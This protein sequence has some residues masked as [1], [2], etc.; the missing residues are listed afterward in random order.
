MSISRI[1]II[2]LDDFAMLT[3]DTSYGYIGGE[4]VQH[5]L[6]ARAWRDLGIDV[7]IIVHD[8]GQPR[9]TGV[10]GIR[11]VACC[12]RQDGVK[13]VRYVY[14]RMTSVLRAMREIDADLYYQSPAGGLAGLVAGFAKQHGKRSIVRI[15]SDSDCMRLRLPLGRRIDRWLYEYGLRN[16]S[17]VAAQTERQR[18]LL[19]RNF[20]V[21]SE[22]MNIVVDPPSS[23]NA[24]ASRDVDVLWVGNFRPVKR[25]DIVLEMARRRPQYRFA[26]VGGSARSPAG[27][28]YFSRVAQEAAS[29]SNVQMTGTVPYEHVGTWFDRA[30]VHVNT[31]DYE[32]FP[33]TFL[34]A[35]IRR[36]PVVSFFDPDNLIERR[37][38]GR[39]CRDVEDMCLALDELL[40]DPSRCAAI[41]E[42]SYAA[43][44][45]QYS[46]REI[47]LRYLEA[48]EGRSASFRVADMTHPSI[49]AANE[50]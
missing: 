49:R 5:V 25:P 4:S 22:I 13:L 45:S 14:P 43:A 16:A 34:Q 12:G 46:A 31:S 21:Q 2:G 41:G 19:S 11:A 20:G 42:R 15:A 23:S 3:G 1:C 37:G 30:R 44:S 26:L 24:A 10:D 28:A 6:L 29:L 39:R 27:Q 50:P 32:G 36:V 35:W 7:S 38:L 18:E 40:G 8:H 47:A 17:L 9:I 33:N 48:I